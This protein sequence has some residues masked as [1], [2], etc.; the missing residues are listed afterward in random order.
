MLIAVAVQGAR[1]GQ[2]LYLDDDLWSKLI[3]S[4][5]D[6][7]LMHQTPGYMAVSALP[8]EEADRYYCDDNS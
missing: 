2:L 5:V 4:C 1:G 6:L 3:L 8:S 7:Q